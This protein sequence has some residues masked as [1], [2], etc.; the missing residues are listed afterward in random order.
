[1]ERYSL[2]AAEDQVN[3]LERAMGSSS[4]GIT[5]ADAQLP[6]LPLIYANKA[7]ERITGYQVEEILG[8]NCRFL[9]GDNP[10]PEP[11]AKIR[12]AL[13][14]G[15]HLSILLK[16][17]RKDGT[18]FWNELTLSPIFND[19]GE[20]THFVGVQTDVTE[21]VEAKRQLQA[22]RETLEETVEQLE[23]AHREKD[24]LMGAVAH[25]LRGPLSS[26]RSLVEVVMEGKEDD[27]EEMLR[28]VADTAGRSLTLVNDLVDLSAIRDG[29]LVLEKQALDLNGFLERFEKNAAVRAKQKDIRFRV[30]RD[31]PEN[32][33]V[34]VDPKRFEQVV[35]N[36]FTNALKFSA[37]G[38][39]VELRA[40]ADDASALF[41]MI[42]EGPGIAEEELPKLFEP[43]EKTSAQPTDGESSS[44]LGLSIVKRL[45]ELNDGEIDV[46]STVGRGSAF[47][48]RLPR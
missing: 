19:A 21:R 45:V 27:P 18:M 26:I 39:S 24:Q 33:T 34:N 5:I 12:D 28:T 8:K 36:L 30:A 35:D 42:D 11:R 10:D 47:R 13:E 41:Q 2:N 25:D 9:Q 3:L 43:F 20:A 16:N 31:I 22:K 4:C 23:K 32:T 15:E 1:M 38:S 14:K 29:Q 17:Y 44:G 40:E 48:V 37:P 6:D 46:Q 7:F